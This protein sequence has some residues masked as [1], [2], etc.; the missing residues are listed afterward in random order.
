MTE[1]RS[2][3]VVGLREGVVIAGLPVLAYFYDFL[4]QSGYCDYFGVPRELIVVD[5]SSIVRTVLTLVLSGAGI[6][7]I[8]LL[9]SGF[10]INSRP[11][12]R[13]GHFFVGAAVMF[14]LFS[15]LVALY[16]NGLIAVYDKG[17]Q[18][19]SGHDLIFALIS[20]VLQVFRTFGIA[21]LVGLAGGIAHSLL[22][23]IFPRIAPSK[24]SGFPKLHK[25]SS[26]VLDKL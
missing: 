17:G 2:N 6:M 12:S 11:L 8:A 4:Y 18:F 3:K 15:S 25:G 14:L 10:R 19:G 9:F 21:M 5:A 16:V 7:A 24:T 13:T 1:L 20:N 23:T 26:E 22:G